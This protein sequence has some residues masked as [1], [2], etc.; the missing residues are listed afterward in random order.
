MSRVHRPRSPWDCRSGDSGPTN[1]TN[2]FKDLGSK[3][4]AKALPRKLNFYIGIQ[5]IQCRVFIINRHAAKKVFFYDGRDI[6]RGGWLDAFKEKNCFLTL[7]KV[8]TV[9]KLE[10]GR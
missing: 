8:L 1:K 9:I 3:F 2:T 10:R 6:E 4:F 5:E 7:K